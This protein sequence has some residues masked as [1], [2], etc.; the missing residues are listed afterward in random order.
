MSRKKKS[1]AW[2]EHTLQRQIA[3][4]STP[5]A[6][7]HVPAGTLPS[8]R[9]SVSHVRPRYSRHMMSRR[10]TR[11]FTSRR[12]RDVARRLLSVGT[13]PPQ[14][15]LKCRVLRFQ[16][17]LLSTARRTGSDV[18]DRR[19]DYRTVNSV[20]RHSCRVTSFAVNNLTRVC[21]GTRRRSSTHRRRRALW[22]TDVTC[23]LSHL[24]AT[25][26]QLSTVNNHI[27]L[28]RTQFTAAE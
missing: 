20:T 26:E 11:R 10:S 2:D 7:P 5:P 15:R 13:K 1:W 4:A 9:Q 18:T 22:C 27:Q 6:R 3:A 19:A 17:T 14:L 8:R 24:P 28:N 25:D 12:R 21:H 23:Q 16:S